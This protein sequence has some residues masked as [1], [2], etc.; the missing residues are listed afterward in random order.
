[1]SIKIEG[2][3][4]RTWAEISLDNAEFNYN[5]IRNHI[6]ESTK[7]CCVIKANAYGHGACMMARLYER[8]GADMLAV[9]NIEE[10][11]QLRQ[12]GIST[13]LLILGYT[14]ADCAQLL[15]SQRIKQCVY[16]YE[17]AA[18]LNSYAS[19]AGVTV[20]IHIKIDT[21]MGRI[22]FPNRI[23]GEGL[24]DALRS[25]QL[26]NL[27]PEGIFTHFAVSDESKDGEEYT[28]EQFANFT[29]AV[30][31]LN[32]YGI[33]FGIRHCANSAA[34]FDY[35]E[36]QLDMVRAGVVLYG[37]KPSDKVGNLS[38]LRPVMALYSVISHIKELYAD[39]TVSYGREFRAVSDMRVATVP[40][41]YAD[42]FRRTCGN[43]HCSLLINGQEAPVL[44]RVCMDQLIVDVSGIDCRAGDT[45]TIFG[46]ARE[47][48]ADDFAAC[49]KTI[50]YETV[51]GI[52]ERVP[53]IYV[54]NGTMVGCEN[55]L[56][57]Y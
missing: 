1:M 29:N 10:A 43:G 32:S 34:I 14:P 57:R 17:Y 46:E 53:R 42:G 4:R 18:E 49:C 31:F 50:N 6:A 15:A 25:C 35:P 19:Q 48:T 28:R 16:S 54:R 22:G 26:S 5:V 8:L 38:A 55:H 41:G 24:N 2:A 3:M 47:H 13:E 20:G 30:E 45:V 51:C 52:G 44:G 37:L 56:V 33:R 27:A 9:S 36:Y 39:E 11:L 7:L 40:V 23:N 12:S 21:G